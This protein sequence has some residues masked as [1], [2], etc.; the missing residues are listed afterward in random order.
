MSPCALGLGAGAATAIT[1]LLACLE[2]AVTA[3]C[4]CWSRRGIWMPSLRFRD[5][6]SKLRSI[7]ASG[8]SKSQAWRRSNHYQPPGRQRP[9]S[10]KKKRE[11][12]E[13][14][15]CET[16]RRAFG[17]TCRLK[18]PAGRPTFIY[19]TM[20]TFRRSLV[21][22]FSCTHLD[23]GSLISIQSHPI[24]NDCCYGVSQ[25]HMSTC[26]NKASTHIR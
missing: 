7:E 22:H 5:G 20:H 26:F 8:Q 10:E 3:I 13:G 17:A 23:I 1:M 21:L 16:T 2:R 11:V 25:S 6:W 9:W 18:R 14:V 15:A 12:D 19:S 4:S 24:M